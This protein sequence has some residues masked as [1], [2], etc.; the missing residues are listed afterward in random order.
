MAYWRNRGGQQGASLGWCAGRLYQETIL[1]HTLKQDIQ[2]AIRQLLKNPSFAIVAVLTLALGIGTNTA[3]FSV[4]NG[5]L[6][7]LPVPDPNQIMVLAA[8]QKGDT[9][10]IYYLSYTDLV[11]FRKQADTFSDL[12]GYQIGLGGFS[13]GGKAEPLLYS[14]VS[15]NFFT[16]LG[17][18]PAAGRLFL[19]NEGEQPGA[20][21]IVV[22]GYS[23][24]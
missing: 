15:G 12:F 22:L 11:D 21:P 4:V 16:A 6:R 2:Y 8:Q 7:P 24:W 14:Y 17:L 18:Q 3:I 19:P 1:V 20:T 23:Y 5:W 10:G 13:A 9:L